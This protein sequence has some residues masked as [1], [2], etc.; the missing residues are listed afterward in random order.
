MNNLFINR[1]AEL[2]YLKQWLGQERKESKILLMRAPTGV[3]KT[4]LVRH[5]VQEATVPVIRVQVVDHPDFT[6]DDGEYL[7]RLFRSLAQQSIRDDR[8]LGI[9][10]FLLLRNGDQTALKAAGA[11]AKHFALNFGK[12]YLGDDGVRA[13]K[14]ILS[15]DVKRLRQL[16]EGRPEIIR[17]EIISYTVAVL[18]SV[19]CIIQIENIQ[20]I[21]RTSLEF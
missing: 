14:D 3:G 20:K 13:V 17:D 8:I 18:S 16:S 19:H 12:K 9:E 21:D 7:L 10:T 4:D 1:K 5:A 2:S 15:T 6:A 11:A